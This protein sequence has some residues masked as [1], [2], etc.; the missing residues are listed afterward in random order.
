VSDNGFY[1]TERKCRLCDEFSTLSRDEFWAHV[2]NCAA[3]CP[4]CDGA[5]EVTFNPGYPDP[6]TEESS[7]CGECFGTGGGA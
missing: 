4:T 2:R 5:G 3:P 6:Q 7:V 1:S